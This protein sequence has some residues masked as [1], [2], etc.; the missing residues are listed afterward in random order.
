MVVE[1]LEKVK[2]LNFGKKIVYEDH[3]RIDDIGLRS[4]NKLTYLEKLSLS[5]YL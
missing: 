2:D 3:N 4:I 1:K 5:T